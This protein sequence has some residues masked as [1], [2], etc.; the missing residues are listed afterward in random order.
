MCPPGCV[1]AANWRC[2]TLVITLF[3][4]FPYSKKHML[5]NSVFAATCFSTAVGTSV[6]IHSLAPHLKNSHLNLIPNLCPYSN[7]YFN[8]IDPLLTLPPSPLTHT[9]TQT[10]LEKHCSGL[11]ISWKQR[12]LRLIRKQ[13]VKMKT[14]F[15]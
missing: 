3:L 2:W 9:Q 6:E 10:L 14:K 5:R 12:S 11:Y 15:H 13:K 4:S 7:P 8:P 1:T